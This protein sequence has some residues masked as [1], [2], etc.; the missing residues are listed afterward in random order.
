[1]VQRL[2]RMEDLA[3]RVKDYVDC[4]VSTDA[5]EVE[6]VLILMGYEDTDGRTDRKTLCDYY[7]ESRHYLYAGSLTHPKT[8]LEIDCS[9]IPL[10]EALR[11]RG[12]ISFTPMSKCRIYTNNSHNIA[13]ILLPIMKALDEEKQNMAFIDDAGSSAFVKLSKFYC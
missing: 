8:G 7:D 9:D 12:D 6:V 10:E 2:N 13:R 4:Y 3:N 1:M 5:S 11:I